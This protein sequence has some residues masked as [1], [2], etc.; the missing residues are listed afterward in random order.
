MV[1]SLLVDALSQPTDIIA[2]LFKEHGDRPE[3]HA[4]VSTFFQDVFASEKAFNEISVLD[5]QHPPESFKLRSLVRFDAMVQDTSCPPEIYLSQTPDGECGGWGLLRAD[6]A[7]DEHKP[8]DYS[9]LQECG[10]VWATSI[11]GRSSWVSGEASGGNHGAT[12]A[13]MPHKYPIPGG[14]HVGAQLKIYDPQLTESLRTTDLHSFIG[15]LTSEARSASI[16]S[17]ETSPVPTVHVV[18]ARPIPLGIVP[19]SFPDQAL[20]PGLKDVREKLISWIADEALAG[21]RLAAEFLLLSIIPKVLSRSPPLLPLS[22]TL[23]GFN[24][25]VQALADVVSQ[26]VPL[27]TTLPLS[28]HHVNDTSFY[29]ESKEEDLHSGW[30]QL[31]KGSLCIISELALTEGTISERGLLNLKQ[32]QDM[33]TSQTLDYAFPFSRYSFETDVSFIALVPGKKS[34][35]FLTH[36]HIPVL[37]KA[38]ADPVATPRTGLQLPPSELLNQFR[39]LVGGAK[40]ATVGLDGD[41]ATFIQDDFVK[42]RQ[43]AQTNKNAGEGTVTSDDLIIRMM[44]AKALAASLHSAEVTPAIWERAKQLEN[45]RRARLV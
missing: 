44:V 13:A 29:P 41:T 26:L 25:E 24:L 34:A 40:V 12:S 31:P 20:L 37:G 19:R 11:P 7:G 27:C 8:V 10:V 3:F 16:E 33:M 39:Q 36:L 43:A 18:F 35:F 45:Q 30:L 28:L 1:S 6:S 32:V 38:S 17:S 42:E 5:V 2:K 22:L 21:D 23:S 15:I 14:S 4:K 9:L